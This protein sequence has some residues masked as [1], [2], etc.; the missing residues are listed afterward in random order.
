MKNIL[1]AGASS[2]IGHEL[3]LQLSGNKNVN[4]FTCS[5]SDIDLLNNRHTHICTDLLNETLPEGFLPDALHGVVYCPGTIN[6]KPFRGLSKKDFED[7]FRINVL[8]AVSLLQQ[9]YKSLKTSG[10]ASVVLFSTVAVH[11]G[12]PFHSSVAA[13]KGALEAL[14]RSLAAEWAPGIRVNVVAPSLTDTPL[15]SRLLSGDSKREAAAARHPLKRSGT[16]AD[17]ASMATFLLS[18]Q[19]SWISGQV[20]GVDGGLSTLKV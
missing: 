3:T 10:N 18:E 2:G 9:V 15:A 16:P 17:I 19:A 14:G 13:A 7:D 12:M 20:I 6:L 11:Q 4:L 8:G 5:R 1:I